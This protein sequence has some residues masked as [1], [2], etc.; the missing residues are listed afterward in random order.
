MIV[1]YTANAEQ[2]WLRTGSKYAVQAV[3]FDRVQGARYRIISD[4]AATPAMFSASDFMLIDRRIPE[5]WC[6]HVHTNG[7]FELSPAAW[8]EP[9]FWERF[10]G[11]KD[12]A[13]QVFDFYTTPIA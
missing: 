1:Q 8:L 11:D 5:S 9:G 12:E 13:K 7:D 6:A 10:F 4:D 3:Y 2:N